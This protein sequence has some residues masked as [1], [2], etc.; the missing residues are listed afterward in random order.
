MQLSVLEKH[1]SRQKSSARSAAK[2]EARTSHL[3]T[4]KRENCYAFLEHEIEI[5]K[6]LKY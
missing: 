2:T 1:V 3:L 5:N 4:R 6:I